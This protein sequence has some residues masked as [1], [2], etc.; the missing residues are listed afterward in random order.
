MHAC[1]LN[2]YI[3]NYNYSLHMHAVRYYSSEGPP[4]LLYIYTCRHAC[5]FSLHAVTA[6]M[7]AC[8]GKKLLT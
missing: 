1:I 3:Y 7:H 5:M 4:Q 6:C 8:M 2:S